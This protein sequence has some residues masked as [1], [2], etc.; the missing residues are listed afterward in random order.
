MYPSF[1]GNSFEP[2]SVQTGH[3][4]LQPDAPDFQRVVEFA[5]FAVPEDGLTLAPPFG[6]E[7]TVWPDGQYVFTCPVSGDGGM[8]MVATHYSYVVEARDGSTALG[9]FALGEQ[10]PEED[11]PDFQAWSLD[12][13][14]AL[15]DAVGLFEGGHD[16]V[17]E[18]S[19]FDAGVQAGPGPGSGLGEADVAFDLLDHAIK[20]SCES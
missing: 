5:G 2:Q 15:E 8:S 12:D 18:L 16:A 9:T 20:T 11:V 7:L 1:V 14:L 3:F 19:G 10:A 4:R 13:I 6:G 17:A